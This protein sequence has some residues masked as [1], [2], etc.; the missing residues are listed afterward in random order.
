MRAVG[1]WMVLGILFGGG[2]APSAGAQS[3]PSL[4]QVE[5]GLERA[6]RW[7]WRVAPP[8]GSEWGLTLTTFPTLRAL[9]AT[10]SPTPATGT[11]APART[12][13][14][15]VKR[16]DALFTI[17]RRFK[18]PVD[19]LKSA[20][21]L[22]GDTIRV[23]Q[24]LRIPAAAEIAATAPRPAAAERRSTPKPGAPAAYDPGALLLQVYLDRALFP[25]GPIDGQPGPALFT[26]Q[27][28]YA[29]AHPG[30]VGPEGLLEQAGASVGDPL[31][32]Y[33]IRPE[34]FRF[35]TPP[36]AQPVALDAPSTPKPKG[37]TAPNLTPKP[38][39]DDLTSSAQLVYRTPW[40]FVAE[41][42]HCNETF[43]RRLNP[44][45]RGV[46][47]AG[48]ELV[49]PNVRPFEIE[50]ALTPP[51]QPAPNTADP[52]T[53]AVVDLTRLEISRGGRLIAAVPLSIARPRLSGRGT[54]TILEAI[55]RPRLA[56]LRELLFPPQPPTRIYGRP[57]A[58]A[59]PVPTPPTLAT[60][61]ILPAGPNNPAGILWISLA[62]ADDPEPL[63]YGLTGT[64]IPDEMPVTESIG[65][66][67]LANWDIARVVRLLP[68][69]TPLEWRQG[70]PVRVAPAVAP[71]AAP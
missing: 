4:T 48:D 58:D 15:V 11:D 36:K 30:T 62:R 20:N 16:G 6:V 44:H 50:T 23:G 5:P 10:A 18:V 8:V 57:D 68:R 60:D 9:P 67:R 52:V 39:Y 33:V 37:R 47:T 32:R 24:T 42:F 19:A 66:L 41:R 35:I 43:L 59:T 12:D 51:L 56:T 45:I 38:T 28:R 55:P 71:A 31:T 40:E 27:Q 63:P 69:G 1:R 22:T 14:Y 29:A 54:W 7:K 17:S 21:G 46:P 13:L 65:G 61:E 2:F 26:A 53:A 70:G 64:S 25:A 3:R 49:V 34:D